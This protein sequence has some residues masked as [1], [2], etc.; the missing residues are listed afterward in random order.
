MQEETE[1]AGSVPVQQM[2]VLDLVQDDPVPDPSTPL[3]DSTMDVEKDTP[4]TKKR[5]RH[6]VAK[7]PRSRLSNSPLN[8]TSSLKGT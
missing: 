8:Q 6:A 5:D 2:P 4:A 7:V 1:D 3:A